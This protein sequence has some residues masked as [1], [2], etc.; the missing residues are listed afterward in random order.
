LKLDLNFL[1]KGVLL[2]HPPTT[3]KV[4]HKSY[5]NDSSFS[6]MHILSNTPSW[7]LQS[8]LILVKSLT[9]RGEAHIDIPR[10]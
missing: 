2:Q 9:T 6:C 7:V 8:D 10:Q 1:N 5:S 3:R 4:Y